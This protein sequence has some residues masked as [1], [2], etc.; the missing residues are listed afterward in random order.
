MELHANT[1]AGTRGRGSTRLEG[2]E[3][4]NRCELRY[5][6][7]EAAEVRPGL[8]VLKFARDTR[9]LGSYRQRQRF[10]PA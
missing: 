4:A 9:Y 3:I 10:D 6:I 1:G 7:A 8:R 2:T 5:L